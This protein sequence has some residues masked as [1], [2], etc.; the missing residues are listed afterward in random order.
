MVVGEMPEGVDLLVVGGGPGGY[1]AAI[2]AAQLGRK[3]VLVD[4]DGEDGLGGVCVRVG[5]IPSKALIE[6]AA[7]V[8]AQPAWAARGAPAVTADPVDLASFQEWRQEVVDGLNDGVRRLLRRAGVEVRRG[9]F[10]FT[11][12]DQGALVT[13]ADR[14]PTHLQFTSCIVATGSRPIELPLLPFDGV[15]IVS[16][17]EALGLTRVPG[18]VAVVGGGY[19]GLELGTA[20]AKL[21]ADV[22]IVEA[23]PTLLPTM[24]PQIGRL[25]AHRVE[26]LGVRVLTGAKVT[27]DTGS[28]LQVGTVDG[29]VEL[30]VELVVVAVGRTPNTD[31]LGLA[32]LGVS[33]GADGRLAVGADLLLTPRVAAIGDITPGPALA[34]K[35]SAEGHVAAAVLSGHPDA[36]DPTTIAA[37]VFSDPEVA[38]AGHTA[39]SASAASHQ[40]ATATFP[41]AASGRAR[42]LGEGA[43]FLEYVYDEATGIVLG[44]TVVGPHAS[45]LIAEAALAVELSAHLEDLAGTIHAHPTL[46]EMHHEAALVGLGRPVHVP[47]ARRP[48]ANGDRS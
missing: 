3:V 20:L 5:C 45:E 40:V 36:F 41:V 11:R 10:R 34:H 13:D 43:G 12:P 23:Q 15:R 27:G 14:P 38:Q 46:A 37:V 25:V 18:S 21:G 44:A 19:I 8:H 9:W 26:E 31:D 4:A 1:V 33:P 2:A 42:T 29:A 28:A 48:A 47:G 24:D 6:L 16:S 30:D 32:A 39:A 17:T 22:S 7:H 35:A